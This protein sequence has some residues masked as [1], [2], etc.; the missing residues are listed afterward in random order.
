MSNSDYLFVPASV[1]NVPFRPLNKGMVRNLQSQ[2]IG[3]TACWTAKNLWAQTQGLYRRPSFEAFGGIGGTGKGEPVRDLMT[4]FSTAG[5]QESVLLDDR[6]LFTILSSGLTQRTSP[7]TTGDD[8]IGGTLGG[9]VVGGTA[10][11]WNTVGSN[12][13]EGDRFILDP[14]GS[15]TSPGPHEYY[16]GVINSDTSL[17]LVTS[18]GVAVS[19]P[20]TFT[21]EDY[22]IERCWYT[23]RPYFVDWIVADN[24]IIFADAG[25]R[26]WSW[27]GTT[28][29][30]YGCTE[31]AAAVYWTAACVGYQGDRIW[32]GDIQDGANRYRNRVKW[33]TVTDHKEFPVANYQDLIHTAGSV[34]RL[35]AMDD[36]MIA[37]LED[38]VYVGRPTNYTDLPFWFKMIETPDAGLVGM[39]AVC[40]AHGGHYFVAH[41]NFWKL[42]GKGLEPIGTPI[43]REALAKCQRKYAIWAAPDIKHHRICFGIPK[44]GEEFEKIWSY[45]YQAEAWS[46]DEVAGSSLSF[47]GLTF[48]FG[49]DDLDTVL[50][51]DNW[52]VGM[53]EFP[54]WDGIGADLVGGELYLGTSSGR[55]RRL[56]EEGDEDP[57]NTPIE[58]VFETGDIDLDLP[59]EEKVYERLSL[60]IDTFLSVDLVF[61]VEVSTNRG[62]TW[63]TVASLGD[64]T[65]LIIE[66]GEDEGFLSFKA[67]GSTVRIRFTSHTVCPPYTISE[68]VLTCLVKGAERNSE[69]QS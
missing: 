69:V 37:Y 44:D 15:L 58:A 13:K 51:T 68:W 8:S 57:D 48:A 22:R 62:R 34:L 45:D 18:V 1:R 64:G 30:A 25:R 14:D 52:D 43:A 56:T 41:D 26:P 65:Q 66:A 32:F 17:D 53:A 19:L 59:N 55:V 29:G 10:T 35:V 6:N 54:S 67:R 24:L 33:S 40:R 46:F 39:K 3:P 49:W 21:N 7:F 4:R 16:I 28:W 61:Q 47:R 27:D 36:W 11:A 5:V 9:Y 31:A 63:D 42:S 50:G 60:K 12:I 23:K 38:A 2:G 20:E